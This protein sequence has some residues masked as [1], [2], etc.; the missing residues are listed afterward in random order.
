VSDRG[1]DRCP[2]CADE[3]V[4]ARILIVLGIDALV[5]TPGGELDRVALDLV[6]SARDGDVVLCHAG[7]ALE[8]LSR[9]PGARLRVIR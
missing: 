4:P 3:A 7:I 8:L 6:P 9:D 5:E 2:T 1:R